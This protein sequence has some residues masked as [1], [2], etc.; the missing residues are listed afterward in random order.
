M[1]W[2]LLLLY[3]IVSTL[4]IAL[5]TS[6]SLNQRFE[7]SIRHYPC[8]SHTKG[9]R[10]DASSVEHLEAFGPVCT[11]VIT[12]SGLLLALSLLCATTDSTVG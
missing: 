10:P 12:A 1:R 6:L 3:Q 5:F 8:V 4:P 11:A 7:V 2:K 9:S